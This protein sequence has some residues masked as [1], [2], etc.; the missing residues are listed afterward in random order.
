L[1]DSCYSYMFR[2][3]TGLTTAPT[4]L[5]ATALDGGC[6]MSM[7]EN[8][9][10]LTNA[11]TLPA[12]APAQNAYS[13]MFCDCFNLQYVKC[14]LETLGDGSVCGGFLP[15][16]E[17]TGTFVKN[18]AN[19][20]WES[21]SNPGIP[22]N[23][24]I[25]SEAVPVSNNWF[26]VTVSEGSVSFRARFDENGQGGDYST[27]GGQNWNHKNEYEEQYFELNAGDTV[28]FH[29]TGNYN[30]KFSIWDGQ[31]DGHIAFSGDLRSVSNEG[32][33]S[34]DTYNTSR[35]AGAF[36]GLQQLYDVSQLTL[37]YTKCTGGASFSQM[38][39]EC[40]NLQNTPIWTITQVEGTND[41]VFDSMF[42]ECSSLT[43]VVDLH[44]MVVGV[45]N[46]TNV[47][48]NM[49]YSCNGLTSI[50]NALPTPASYK[51]VSITG[52][53]RECHNLQRVEDGMFDIPEILDVI[54]MSG[55]FENCYMLQ[56]LKIY[57]WFPLYENWLH[58][59]GLDTSPTI[60]L[61]A[62]AQPYESSQRRDGWGIP[63]NWSIE[64]YS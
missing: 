39:R 5:P 15:Q 32:Y 16:T 23:W 50:S 49:Y 64:Y 53:F 14:L 18:S 46:N 51:N 43:S 57:S 37:G 22:Q 33:A 2:G 1:A 27:D 62:G 34:I 13:Y 3:C 26:T 63:E 35:H 29:A 31:G 4:T 44:N 52:M 42:N 40:R 58:E 11:P 61:P 38:F 28:M 24:T 10:S 60:Y 55:L 30:A 9:T 19:N 6:Y 25:E 17:T 54:D 47:F 45:V 48:Q 8:C 41:T 20:E 12:T 56:Y 7:F 59:A 36:Y 21:W